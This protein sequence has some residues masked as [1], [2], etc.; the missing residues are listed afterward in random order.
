LGMVPKKDT[1]KFRY[2]VNMRNV[3]LVTRFLHKTYIYILTRCYD[4][5]PMKNFY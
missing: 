4:I 5:R 3:T 1:D 2:I